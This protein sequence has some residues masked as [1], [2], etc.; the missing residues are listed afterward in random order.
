MLHL[1]PFLSVLSSYVSIITT[2]TQGRQKFIVL[3]FR[4]ERKEKQE[5]ILLPLPLPRQ[6]R[7]LSSLLPLL[8]PTP[9]GKRWWD[10]VL[11][12]IRLTFSSSS[13]GGVRLALSSTQKVTISP[14]PFTVTFTELDES[15]TYVF[16][17]SYKE[18]MK[19]NLERKP[20]FT[21]PL[22]LTE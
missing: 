9:N 8:Q 7:L 12:Q 15:Q 13:I 14:L 10:N 2:T 3:L 17:V 18:L 1:S 5:L 11:C 21:L 6:L 22:S 20:N 4:K 16:D 19:E